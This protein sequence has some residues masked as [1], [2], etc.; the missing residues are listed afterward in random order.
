MENQETSYEQ[1]HSTLQDRLTNFLNAILDQAGL[2]VD[3]AG[4]ILR[5]II[6]QGIPPLPAISF[7]KLK[8]LLQFR[9]KDPLAKRPGRLIRRTVRASGSPAF[10]L[11][12]QTI[13][14]SNI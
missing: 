14:A 1:L 4:E 12:S 9:Q 11:M 10:E 6:P 5:Q 2:L 3:K 13:S 7:S 8:R